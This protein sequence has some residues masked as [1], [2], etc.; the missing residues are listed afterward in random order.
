MRQKLRCTPRLLFGNGCVCKDD[1]AGVKMLFSSLA[2]AKIYFLQMGLYSLL[3][4][5]LIL[6][7]S[8]IKCEN[9]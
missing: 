4:D 5:A 7:F 1:N 8:G 2:D 3:S 9:F 6:C